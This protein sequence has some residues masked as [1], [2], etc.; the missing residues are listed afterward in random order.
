M[1]S[2]KPLLISLIEKEMGLRDLDLANGGVLNTR[3]VAKFR[4]NHTLN[5]DS[6]DKVCLFLDIPIEK[7]VEIIKD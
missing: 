3:T 7:V 2:Y 5:I 1:I 4:H 6:V